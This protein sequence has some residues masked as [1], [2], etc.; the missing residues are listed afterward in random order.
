VPVVGRTGSVIAALSLS[1]PSVRF[2]DER[3]GEFVDA[4]TEV[5]AHMNERGFDHPFRM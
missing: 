4:L 2:P 5:A 3:V 1:G